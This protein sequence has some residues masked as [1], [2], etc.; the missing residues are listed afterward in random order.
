MTPPLDAL[1][2]ALNDVDSLIGHHPK[3][4][5]PPPGRPT[6]DH[7]PLLRSCVV[8]IYAAWEVYVEESVVWAVDQLAEHTEPDQLPNALR[9]FV[10]AAYAKDPW[11]LADGWREATVEAVTARVRGDETTGTSGLNTAGPG[12]VRRL[13]GDILGRPE[14]L[15]HCGWTHYPAGR[16][17]TDLATVID[18]RGSIA[19]TGTTPG[20][21]D[22]G[23]VRSWRW[24]VH[25]LATTLD[26][27]L[28]DAAG[29]ATR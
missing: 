25:T 24:F 29:G 14:L 8:L 22:L 16:V 21:L 12:Q 23:G 11:Q 17:K 28:V 2:R 6:G 5:D 7:G 1:E 18:V 3:A 13:H 27:H 10:A 26:G 19:H 9:E 20:N 4:T 15:D